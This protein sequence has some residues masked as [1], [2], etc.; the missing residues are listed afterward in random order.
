[1]KTEHWIHDFE[2]NPE[3]EFGFIYYVKNLK[4]GKKYIGKKQYFTYRKNKKYKMSNWKKYTSSSKHLNEDIK[5]YGM[6]N[7]EFRIL[8]E[9]SSRGELTY[10]EANLQHKYDVLIE[11]D[12]DGNRIW[13]NANIASVKFIPKI[14][15]KKEAHLDLS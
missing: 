10:H 14:S 8:F 5:E 13:Y 12:S 1:M 9:C 11:R 7:F 3:N 6:E 15:I 4:T 2:L